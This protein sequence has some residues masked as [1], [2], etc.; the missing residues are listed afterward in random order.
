MENE[1][2][3][4]RLLTEIRD[5]QQRQL[6]SNQSSQRQYFEFYNAALAKQQRNARFIAI[7]IG[8]GAAL[9]LVAALW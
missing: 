2:E 8:V 4:I 7:V 3:I 9:V 6:E 5:N 1:S